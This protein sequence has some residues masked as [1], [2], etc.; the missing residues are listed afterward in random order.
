MFVHLV[1][2]SVQTQQPE[3]HKWKPN[4]N[5]SEPIL[6]QNLDIESKFRLFKIYNHDGTCSFSAAKWRV[7][8]KR[9]IWRIYEYVRR[10]GDCCPRDDYKS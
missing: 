4:S 7:H 10:G 8:F 3:K 9:E 2:N 6:L 5:K 1:V